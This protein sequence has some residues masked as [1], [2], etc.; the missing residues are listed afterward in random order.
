MDLIDDT[1]PVI[2]ECRRVIDSM[3]IYKCHFDVK[4]TDAHDLE[5]VHLLLKSSFAHINDTT[6]K[7]GE[8][9]FVCS[10]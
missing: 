10:N 6:P 3:F 7:F 2:T 4:M 8:R 1:N 5:K 9:P